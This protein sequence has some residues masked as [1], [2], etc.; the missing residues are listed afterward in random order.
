MEG[1]EAGW[2]EEPHSGKY[3]SKTANNRLR[4]IN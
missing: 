3:G 4:Q 1:G 2:G